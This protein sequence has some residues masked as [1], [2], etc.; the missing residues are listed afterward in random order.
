MEI[1]N[2]SLPATNR[3]ATEYLAQN[4]TMEG[5]FH[6]NFLKSSEYKERLSELN[7]RTFI[8]SE[9]AEH[10]EHFMSRFPSSFQVKESI[11]KLKKDNSVVVI[12]GQQ[13]GLL[14]GP[15]YSIHK[16]ISII[17]LA[18]EQERKLGVPVIPVFWIA[19][20]DHDYQEV[21]HVYIHKDKKVEKSIYPEKIREKKM[22]SDIKL[23]KDVCSAWIM[24]LIETFG[25]TQH[26]NELIEFT[27]QALQQS[28]T[29]VDFFA[30]IVME[31]FKDYGLLII[32]SGDPNLRRLESEYFLRQISNAGQITHL[33]KSQ[34]QEIKQ[35][36]FPQ[37][38]DL[39]DHAG[40]LFYYDEQDQERIL[41]EYDPDA[42]LFKGKNDLVQFSTNELLELALEYPEKLSNNVVTRPIMQEWL[43]P[44]LAF[45]AGP[46][47]ISYWAELKKAFEYFDMKMPIIVPRLNITL[48]ERHIDSDI[49]SFHL[50]VEKVLIEGISKS[51]EE[52]LQSLK[53][54]NL[55][56]LFEKTS[57]QLLENYEQIKEC[58]NMEDKGLIPLIEKNGSIL[59]EQLQF[60][61]KRIEES[62]QSKNLVVL[63]KYTAIENSLK[64]LGSPQERIW[65]IYYYLNQ[66]GF[67]LIH[68]VMKLHFEFDGTHKVIK[69]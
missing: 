54:K 64:P 6:Y 38:I 9:L 51:R 11:E 21:N 10:I 59:G 14:T 44:T 41:L 27:N 31:L 36:G 65:N 8:R 7:N 32:D 18:K 69:I 3:F 67:Q 45:I 52:F 16:V 43:F 55:E 50:S 33:V 17:V 15:L 30:H 12:G 26:T 66:Y 63:N 40:N 13:A 61:R 24:S 22:V 4:Q 25:E 20:E 42:A 68:E 35:F 57:K 5:L 49:D 39:S 62:I 60:M 29:F 34:Q 46:G 53:N 19:G 58:A 1:L 23:N 56:R 47:E 2:L 37:A 28:H 48:L